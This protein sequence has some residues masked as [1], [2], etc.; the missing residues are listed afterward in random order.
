ML[1]KRKEKGVRREVEKSGK[2]QVL[3]ASIHW[4]PALS[5]HGHGRNGSAQTGHAARGERGVTHISALAPFA[6]STNCWLS[7]AN[8]SD[9]PA[10]IGLQHGHAGPGAGG[11]NFRRS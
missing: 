4:G 5:S 1:M 3:P 6:E 11:S 2:W 9:Q 10:A 8:F 7:A